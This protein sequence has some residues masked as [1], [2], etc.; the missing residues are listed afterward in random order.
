MIE[1]LEKLLGGYEMCGDFLH[2]S[3]GER[4]CD[5]KDSHSYYIYT[6]VRVCPAI[7]G[8]PL[9]KR[10]L[11][12]EYQ[13][14]FLWLPHLRAGKSMSEAIRR[15][16]AERAGLWVWT[17]PSV[18][19]QYANI[20]EA[21]VGPALVPDAS[22]LLQAMDGTHI[23]TLPGSAGDGVI[24]RK[25]SSKRARTTALNHGKVVTQTANKPGTHSGKGP[26]DLR[27]L[28]QWWVLCWPR[29]S[30][31]TPELHCCNFVDGAAK[32]CGL[33]AKRRTQH[34]H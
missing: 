12:T 18:C 9:L 3:T 14:R 26:E 10:C 20:A 34:P 15:T 30:K 5:K 2:A 13:A 29:C 7:G 1:L 4:W 24:D 11:E 31:K 27:R 21:T 17:T 16:E 19:S 32:L 6:K 28:Q 23:V 8:S 25:G 22:G 33:T